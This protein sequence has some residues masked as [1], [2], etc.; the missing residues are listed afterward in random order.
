MSFIAADAT[1][2]MFD[3]IRKVKI[4][5]KKKMILGL[6]AA[7]MS[8]TVNAQQVLSLDQC[9][10]MAV[11][12]N[13]ALEQARAQVTMAGYDRKIA[14]ANYFPNISATGTYLHNSDNIALVSDDMSTTLQNAGTA[15]QGKLSAQMQTLMQAITSNP[16]AAAEYMTSPMWQ[17]VLGALSQTD[18]S[19]GINAIGTEIDDA[20]HLDIED[21]FLGAVSVQQPVFMGGKIIAAN[22]IA[23]LAEELAENKYE[24]EY[25]QILVDV[26]Q[27][28]WQIVS[29]AA[30]RNLAESYA[31]LLHQMQHNADLAVEAGVKTASDALTIKVK[32]N[33]ADMLKT[34]STNGLKLAKMLL[35]KQIGLPLDSDIRLVDEDCSIIPEPQMGAA[36]SMDE[37]YADRPEIRSLDIAAQIY[38]KKVAVARADMMPKVALM[39][40][41]LYSN[42]SMN[43]GFQTEWGGRWSAG[44]MVNIPIFHAFEATNKTRKAKAEATIYRNRLEDTKNMVNLQ[45]TQLHHQQDEALERLRMAENNLESAEENLRT[46]TV[47]FEEGVIA[48]DVALAAQTAWLQAHSEYIDAGIELQMT[49]AQI[50][51]AEGNYDKSE[52][53]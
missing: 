3:K 34:K 43:N 22:R 31:D 9:R 42:P 13:K 29:I 11:S 2:R 5:M 28:Y 18:L 33:E 4:L 8:L 32:T 53:K 51:K 47:G 1:E 16:A 52:I 12:N 26:D 50:R 37:I 10:E 40:A 17:T 14:L 36:K 25:Q 35:C 24:T 38:D 46:A 15:V 23:R 49:A 21:V 19:A 27:A 41:Y 39:G 7:T 20:F 48:S 45:V 44:V 30:K 6:L